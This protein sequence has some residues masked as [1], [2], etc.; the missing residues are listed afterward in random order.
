MDVVPFAS[1]RAYLKDLL[2]LE[3]DADNAVHLLRDCQATSEQNRSELGGER[4]D[5]EASC[6]ILFRTGPRPVPY[7]VDGATIYVSKEPC[8]PAAKILV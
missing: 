6:D 3:R 5:W 2:V 4:W 8:S 1:S 7:M